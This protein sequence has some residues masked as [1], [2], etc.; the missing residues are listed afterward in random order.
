MK[1][2]KKITD[3]GEV[4]F[5]PNFVSSKDFELLAEKY[6]EYTYPI[7]GWEWVE[8]Y[9]PENTDGEIVSEELALL[10]QQNELL[11]QIDSYE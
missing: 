7:D 1:G 6:D 2:F 5:A 11:K 4:L 8:D 3:T 9:E 10:R